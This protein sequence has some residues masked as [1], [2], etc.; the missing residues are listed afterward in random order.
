LTCVR[1]ISYALIHLSSQA[2][3]KRFVALGTEYAEYLKVAKA[4]EGTLFIL[5]LLFLLYFYFAGCL[6]SFLSL[7]DCSYSSNGQC[8]YCILEAELSTSQKAYDVATAAKA[9]AEKSQKSALGKA[10]KAKK[11]LADANKEHTQ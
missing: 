8:P 7:L 9:N 10:K 11:A 4:S 2:L 1:C 6:T 5:F 3:L